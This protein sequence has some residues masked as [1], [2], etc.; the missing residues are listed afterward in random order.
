MISGLLL[1]SVAVFGIMVLFGK[2]KPEHIFKFAI[3]LIFAPVL[4][5]V[6]YNHALWFWL[7]LPLWMRI[8]SILLVPFVFSAILRLMFP[9][10]K[11]I[12]S[13][14]TTIFQ[15]LIYFITFPF[16]FLWR[17]GRFFFERERRTQKLN[18]YRPV[19]GSRPPLQNERREANPRANIFD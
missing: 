9:Q 1:L 4:L 10:A 8:L 2:A 3:V 13:L 6:G 15:I 7:G 19:V 11:W 5:A 14:Q 12:Q 18:P 17:A 16:R